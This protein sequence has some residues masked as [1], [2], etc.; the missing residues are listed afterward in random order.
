MRCV[1]SFWL[2][3]RVDR[4][5]GRRRCCGG[6]SLFEAV[7]LVLQG[8]EQAID[9]ALV[10]FAGEVAAIADHQADVGDGHVEYFPTVFRFAQALIDRNRLG[11]R[12]V[13][14]AAYRHFVAALRLGR[15]PETD[16]LAAIASQRTGVGAN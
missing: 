8:F 6:G 5:I 16:R 15:W 1:V 14:L 12:L 4:G 7:V 3:L 9:T 2:V 11:T 13:D 10:H